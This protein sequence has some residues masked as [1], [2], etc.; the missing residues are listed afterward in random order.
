MTCHLTA[1][2]HRHICLS[3]GV[4]RKQLVSGWNDAIDP[5][6][7]SLR[8]ADAGRTDD[9]PARGDAFMM[10]VICKQ[11]NRSFCLL[12]RVWSH[13]L[14]RGEPKRQRDHRDEAKDAIERSDKRIAR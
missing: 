6:R 8:L 12:A 2:A 7:K 13:P 10:A 11:R 5:E 3:F 1:L 9:R 4:D 14:C